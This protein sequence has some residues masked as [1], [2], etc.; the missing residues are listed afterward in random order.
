MKTKEQRYND[1]YTFEKTEYWL[2][3]G[4]S[5]D[6]FPEFTVNARLVQ[7]CARQHIREQLKKWEDDNIDL[8]DM[9]HQLESVIRKF[10]DVQ[11]NVIN[12]K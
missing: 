3:N 1:K 11:E 12:G 6:R 9:I 4:P 5:Y 8:E 7:A 10:E 2:G